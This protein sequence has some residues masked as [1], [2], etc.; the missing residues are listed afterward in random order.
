V[1]NAQVLRRIEAVERS[2]EKNVKI[3]VPSDRDLVNVIGEMSGGLPPGVGV[4]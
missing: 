4:K 1:G 3:V 2:L